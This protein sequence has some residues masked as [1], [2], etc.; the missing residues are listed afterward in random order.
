MTHE[1]KKS[2]EIDFSTF[3]LS[4]ATSVQVHL[5][6]VP[7]PATGKQEKDMVLAKQ[8]VDII[9]MLETKTKGNLTNEESRLIEHVLYDLRMMYV[10]AKKS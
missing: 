5:G 7:N 10:E 8:T 3:V 1:G 2:V 9:A 4:L 6:S